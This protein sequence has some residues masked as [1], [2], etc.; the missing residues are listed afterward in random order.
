[1]FPAALELVGDLAS[2]ALSDYLPE[3]IRIQVEIIFR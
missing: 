2:H 1:M 3:R